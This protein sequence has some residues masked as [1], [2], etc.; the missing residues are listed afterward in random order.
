[1]QVTAPASDRSPSAIHVVLMRGGTSKGVFVREADLPPAGPQRDAF[2]L[3]LMGSPDP[4]QLDGLGGTHSSTS[5]LMAVSPGLDPEIDAEYLFAQVGVDEPVVDWAGNCGN[6]TAAVGAYAVDEGF[7]EPTEPVTAVRLLNR[8][9][10]VRVIAHVPTAGGRAH[11]EGEERLDGLPTPGATLLTEWLDPAGSV[12]G[13]LLPTGSPVDTIDTPTGS[14]AVSIVDV[15][16][17]AAFVTAEA[18]DLRGDESAAELNADAALLARLQAIRDACAARIG[19]TSPTVPRIALVSAPPGPEADLTARVISMGRVHHA[20]AMT[21]A[22]CTAAAARL[23]GTVV[24]AVARPG[25]GAEVRIAHP[26]GLIA[27]QVKLDGGRV[28]SASVVRTARRLLEGV[29]YVRGSYP[30]PDVAAPTIGA[31]AS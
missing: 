7:A 11:S 22:M 5:K 8:N 12:T 16:H 31:V 15:A 27:P 9:T 2:V 18:L 20:Y 25:T 6:L 3:E 26:K 28:R 17:P 19:S 4:M 30:V 23:P 14:Y 1:M 24:H 21:A 13:A 29:A 10:G